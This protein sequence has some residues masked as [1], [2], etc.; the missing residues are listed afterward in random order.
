[1][2]DLHI[3]TGGPTRHRMVAVAA[4]L[5]GLLVVGLGGTVVGAESPAFR[6]SRIPLVGRTT[7]ICSVTEPD[8]EVPT[9]QVAAVV[10]RQAPGREGELTGTPLGADKPSLTITEQGKAKQLPGIRE[11]M[12][13]AGEGVMATASTAAV[14]SLASEG[15]DTGLMAAPCLAPATSQWFTGVGA[16]DADRTEL[17]L[18]NADD[19]QAQVDLRFYGRNGRVVVPGSPG[20]VIEAH[21]SRT[22][23]LSSL[24]TVE[25]PLGLAVQA[26]EGRV[27][28]VAK[29]IR[30]DKLKPVGVDWQLPTAA[31]ATMLAIPAVPEDRGPRELVVTN[32]GTE[33]A[34]V[35]VQVL[36]LQGAYAPA[37]AETLNV[38]A[39]S[40]ASVNLEPGLA[41]EAGT[42]K[43]RSDQPVVGAVI[44]SSDRD[45]AEA[46]LAVQSAAVPLVRT[47]VSA[48]ATTESLAS[49]LVLSNT[50]AEDTSVSFEVISFDGVQLRSDDVL[51]GPDSTATRRLTSTPPSYVVVRVPDGSSIVGGVVLTQPEGKVASLATVPL[52]SPDVASRA[53]RTQLDPAVGR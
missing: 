30:T 20:L 37:G 11:P 31:P 36:G 7:T 39:E 10:S 15:V 3:R 33:R 21:S 17:V 24:V 12:V 49:Q 43:L 27:T 34:S 26:S 46:D 29:R 6:P 1:M 42:V 18:T 9:Q 41:G 48:L 4:V 16:N 53:P 22:V 50:G 45:G 51:L 28:A 23:S 52:T 44:S 14:F 35:T 19:A 38:P 40:S 13:M 25:G 5:I 32:P 47:G 2:T 8:G